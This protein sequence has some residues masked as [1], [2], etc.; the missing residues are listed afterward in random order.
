MDKDVA[1]GQSNEL[2]KAGTVYDLHGFYDYA[3]CLLSSTRRFEVYFEP[4]P[5]V[6]E[7]QVPVSIEFNRVSLLQFSLNFGAFDV[8]DLDELGYKA[9]SDQD[10]RWLLTEQ[11]A[12]SKD[13]VF[14]RFTDGAF[15]RV[16]SETARLCEGRRFPLCPEEERG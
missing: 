9:P 2:I 14:F 12:T 6:G 5:Q 7:G 15:I 13:H 1:V 4:N 11:Q 16:S 10:D 3:G 8:Q